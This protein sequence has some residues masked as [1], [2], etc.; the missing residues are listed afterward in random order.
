MLLCLCNLNIIIGSSRSILNK[1]PSRNDVLRVLR[2]RSAD[3]YDIGI[4][5]DSV[6][7][8]DTINKRKGLLRNVA[9]SDSASLETILDTWL[10]QGGASSTWDQLIEALK[11]LKYIDVVM[12]IK[13]FLGLTD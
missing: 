9:L 4:V 3:W 11:E 12:N 7:G 13:E 8:N 10:Q 6:S 1:T 2:N 5:L